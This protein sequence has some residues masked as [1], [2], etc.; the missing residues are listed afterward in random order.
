MPVL[1]IVHQADAGAGVFGEVVR[2]RGDTLEEWNPVAG[3]PKPDLDG[4][5]AAFTFGGAMNVT[6]DL[7]S[8]NLEKQALASLCD[9]GV[10]LLGICL[11]AELL[12]E[13]AGG[14][15][16]RVEPE[17]GWLEVEVTEAARQDPVLGGLPHSFSAFQWHSYG[18]D[19]PSEAVE[20]AHSPSC[21]QAFRIA[22]AWAIQFHA[23]VTQADAE[24][25]ADDY[26]SDPDA[27][28][29]NL[30]PEALRTEIRERIRE[31]NQLGREL[32]SQFLAAATRA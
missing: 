23:E 22:N 9:R 13:V 6:D 12:A 28:A 27:V 31:W 30:D 29:M 2:A 21:S 19:P 18:F 10:P 5:D 14:T 32:C 15:V 11:G 16:H 25:W 7:P 24:H 1:A 17:I 8:L 20:L 26:A 3:E 4:Y